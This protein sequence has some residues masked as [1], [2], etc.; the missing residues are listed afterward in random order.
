MKK[1]NKATEEFALHQIPDND[2]FKLEV[3]NKKEGFLFK[4]GGYLSIVLVL[5]FL[6]TV[7]ILL[8]KQ[9]LL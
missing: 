4:R 3:L 9:H 1:N 8:E 7:Y 2:Y 5:F 6:L